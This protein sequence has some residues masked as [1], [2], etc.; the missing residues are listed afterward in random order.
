MATPSRSDSHEGQARREASVR[1]PG[2][3]AAPPIDS[4]GISSDNLEGIETRSTPK[5]H[6]YRENLRRHHA[7]LK[8]TGS[9]LWKGLTFEH[10]RDLRFVDS[11][12]SEFLQVADVIAYN[13]F[14]QFRQYGEEWETRGLTA[15]PSYDWFSRLLKKFRAGPDGRI[16]GF[17]V[18]KI[19]LRT[20]VPWRI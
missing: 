8:R 5:G 9:S 7:Q 6:Q 18:G 17:G 20:R 16:Q 15:L 3:V 13:V 12:Q 19:P 2:Q 4:A 14:R 1:E 10:L 11:R